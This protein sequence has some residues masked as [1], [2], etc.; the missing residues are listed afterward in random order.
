MNDY[1]KE[2]EFLN[3][4]DPAIQRAVS[5]YSSPNRTERENDRYHC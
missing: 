4:T 3:Y 1:L 5:Q 2:T